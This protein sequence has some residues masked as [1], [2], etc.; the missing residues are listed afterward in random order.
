M[1]GQNIFNLL[2]I[3]IHSTADDG[4][5]LTIGKVKIAFVIDVAHITGGCPAF[6][7]VSILRFFRLIVIMEASLLAAEIDCSYFS[8]WQ[9]R[10]LII[11]NMQ[12]AH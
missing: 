7:V 9:F 1:D 11:D 6:V 12:L 10:A 2:R 4:E 3:D 8:V 5:V